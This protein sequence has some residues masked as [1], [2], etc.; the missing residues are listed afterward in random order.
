MD[1][2]TWD[3][4]TLFQVPDDPIEF[5]PCPPDTIT[6]LKE[7]A[8]GMMQTEVTA[9]IASKKFLHHSLLDLYS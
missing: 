8:K 3:C 9:Y 1:G 6:Q 2:L 7:T 4:N 5:P